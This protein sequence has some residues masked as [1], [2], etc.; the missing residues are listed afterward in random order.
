MCKFRLS[1]HDLR[2]ERGRYENIARAERICKFCNMSMT[3]NEYHFLHVCPLYAELRRKF[4]KPY[5]CHWPNMNKFDN[6]MMS[7]SKQVILNV[8]KFIYYA[9][10][11][12]KVELN[13]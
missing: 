11:M 8:A 6:L 1:S 4:L 13:V 12:R 3:E 5:F 2:V 7:N 9:L 10:E